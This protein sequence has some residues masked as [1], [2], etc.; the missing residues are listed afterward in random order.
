MTNRERGPATVKQLFFS[1]NSSKPLPSAISKH[2]DDLFS[3][4]VMGFREVLATIVFGK[5][6]DRGYSARNDL[7]GC[8]PRPLYEKG[9]KPI[10]DERGVPSGQSGP[11]NITKGISQLNEQWAAGRR[12]KDQGAANALLGIVDWLEGTPESELIDLANEIGLRFDLLA[13]TVVLTQVSHDPNTSAVSLT[14]AC[15]DLLENHV[16]GGA[17]PQ[18]LCGLALESTFANRGGYKVDG[19]R[20]SASTTNK[21]SKKV[22]DLSVWHDALLLDTFEVTV[23]KFDSKRV[24]EAVQSI[25]AYFEPNSV[26][27]DF[28]VKV[29]CRV[30]DVPEEMSR[31]DSSALLGELQAEEVLFEFISIKDWL[32]LQIAAFDI[33]RRIAFFESVQQ[34]LNGGRVPVEARQTWSRYF[35]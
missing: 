35:S 13:T 6:L 7:Y 11:L 15:I 34:F 9:L 14:N 22:G 8:K 5:Y 30:Q 21:T 3:S 20:D 1:S 24:S 12:K 33:A 17:I 16:S 23:K 25:R 28:T 4:S 29:L 10:F 26:P 32:A 19:A 27:E 31:A 2:L 18:A